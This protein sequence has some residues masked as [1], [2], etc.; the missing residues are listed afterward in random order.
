MK[1]VGSVEEVKV[2]AAVGVV[3]VVGSEAAGV[4]FLW[5]GVKVTLEGA[6]ISAIGGSVAQS[7]ATVDFLLRSH[8]A[9][10]EAAAVKLEAAM[11]EP[12]RA[13][14]GRRKTKKVRHRI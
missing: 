6:G 8:L 11:I 7:L 2:L 9:A 10:A 1:V 13:G 12:F 5:E 4:L 3:G 14:S